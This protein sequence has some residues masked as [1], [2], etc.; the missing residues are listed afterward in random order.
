MKRGGFHS[1]KKKCDYKRKQ[2]LKPKLTVSANRELQMR[3]DE[4]EQRFVEVLQLFFLCSDGCRPFDCENS[5]F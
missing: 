2:Q 4:K 5:L 1:R 3:D